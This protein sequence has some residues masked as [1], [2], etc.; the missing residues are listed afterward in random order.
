MW[1]RFY[2]R[3]V[4]KKQGKQNGR[5]K[6]VTKLWP[7]TKQKDNAFIATF[8]ILTNTQMMLCISSRSVGYSLITSTVVPYIFSARTHL[9]LVLLI[10]FSPSGPDPFPTELRDGYPLMRIVLATSVILFELIRVRYSYR[11]IV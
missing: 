9:L 1:N 10:H 2:H 6:I 7:R 5:V 11:Q 3:L 8:I 4:P